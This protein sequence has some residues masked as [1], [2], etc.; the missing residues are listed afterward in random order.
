MLCDPGDPHRPEL[1]NHLVHPDV[2]PSVDNLA[3]PPRARD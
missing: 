2:S 3:E 1:Q